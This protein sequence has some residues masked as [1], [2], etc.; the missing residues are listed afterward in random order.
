MWG[1]QCQHSF[2]QL[3]WYCPNQWEITVHF[4]V[5]MIMDNNSIL[6]LSLEF[7][8]EENVRRWHSLWKSLPNKTTNHNVWNFL[9]WHHLSVPPRIIFWSDAIKVWLGLPTAANHGICWNNYMFE[10]RQHVVM[11]ERIQ[12]PVSKNRGS[13]HWSPAVLC[14]SLIVCP[15]F[16]LCWQQPRA[17]TSTA[18]RGLCHIW[19]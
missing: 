18:T 19:T 8:T 13:K 2:Q 10:V 3:S 16:L 17:V 1:S 6:P 14:R 15:D 7:S 9:I 4:S 5:P 12:R 11:D